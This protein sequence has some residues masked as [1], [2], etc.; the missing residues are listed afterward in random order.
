MPKEVDEDICGEFGLLV[1]SGGEFEVV[2]REAV[3]RL[4]AGFLGQMN[5]LPLA[6]GIAFLPR[7]RGVDL[8]QVL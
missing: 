6:H 4:P 2:F 8:Y 1:G 7:G 5:H 3:E